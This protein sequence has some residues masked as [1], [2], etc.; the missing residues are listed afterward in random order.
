MNGTI[1]YLICRQ[2]RPDKGCHCYF[3]LLAAVAVQLS[4]PQPVS[5]DKLSWAF[6]EI[7]VVGAGIQTLES[8]L[9]RGEIRLVRCAVLHSL[10]EK[11]LPWRGPTISSFIYKLD[12]VISSQT[13]FQNCQ[14]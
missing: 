9:L 1:F 2:L 14:R 4:N 11:A 8:E 10:V 12:V 7:S 5:A 6:S 3:S 13:T